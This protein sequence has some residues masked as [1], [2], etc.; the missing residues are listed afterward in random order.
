[1]DVLPGDLEADAQDG[2]AGLTG[3]IG[4]ANLQDVL[5]P[6]LAVDGVSHGFALP[7]RKDSALSRDSY[8]AD[9]FHVRRIAP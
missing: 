6:E 4:P 9:L 7:R 8:H 3:S 2:Q 1:M 5:G